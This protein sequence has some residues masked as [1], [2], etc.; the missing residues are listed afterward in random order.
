MEN[1]PPT[2]VATT[3]RPIWPAPMAR[4]LTK[5]SSVLPWRRKKKKPTARAPSM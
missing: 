1:P 4:S 3:D 5:Y 2:S